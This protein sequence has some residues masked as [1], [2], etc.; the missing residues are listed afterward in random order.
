MTRR[1]HALLTKMD[2]AW[3]QM[4]SEVAYI[5]KSGDPHQNLLDVIGLHANSVE[6][7]QRYSESIQQLYNQLTLQFGHGFGDLIADYINERGKLILKNLNVELGDVKL[8]LLEKFFLSEPNLLSGPLIDDIP[9]SEI[10]AI[11]AYDK[12]NQ[13]YIQWLASSDAE[14][15]RKL[16][17]GG[18][19]A[20]N[21]L[22][23][24]LLRHSLM[25][26]QSDAGVNILLANK[27][28]ESKKVFH[29]PAFINFQS[30]GQS[31]NKSKFE[32]L[33][34]PNKTITGNDNTFLIDYIYRPEVLKN[35]AETINLRATLDS[36]KILEKVPTGPAGTIAYRAYRLLQLPY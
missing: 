29:D 13:N 22:L 11:R 12:K 31:K 16:D 5:G 24:L 2:T 19:T 6:F 9:G 35:A 18:N 17:F 27:M 8:P 20:P 3:D 25:L 32:H 30:E 7:H 14:T 36:L 15:I 26:A 4:V 1:L 23:F 21:A 28:V 34:A 10:K 33:Y